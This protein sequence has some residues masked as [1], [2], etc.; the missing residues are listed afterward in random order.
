MAVVDGAHVG[1]TGGPAVLLPGGRR[2]IHADREAIAGA[3]AVV[4][5]PERASH[6]GCTGS[7]GKATGA[8]EPVSDALVHPGS[9][10]GRP[11][12]LL[13]VRD[14]DGDGDASR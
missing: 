14:P 10:G 8:G 12:E 6:T 4:I 13:V 7:T 5:R 2:A 9:H 1:D 3:D 11:G